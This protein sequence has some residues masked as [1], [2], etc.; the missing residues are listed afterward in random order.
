MDA[1]PKP[2]GVIDSH[3]WE[4]ASYD[5]HGNVALPA[6]TYEWF[7][8]DTEWDDDDQTWVINWQHVLEGPFAHA[9]D[10]AAAL[11]QLGGE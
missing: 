11:D 7:I 3:F 10:A 1:T 4:E 2:V 8:C 5:E 6:G 9:D